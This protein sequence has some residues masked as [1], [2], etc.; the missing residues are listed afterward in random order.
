MK[1][2]KGLKVGI[3]L[4]VAMVLIIENNS[5]FS[6]SLFK[7]ENI[8]SQEENEAVEVID[9]E[10]PTTGEDKSSI[11]VN[12][13]EEEFKVIDEDV[14]I[15]EDVELMSLSG[16]YIFD[17]QADT[18]NRPASLSVSI[19]LDGSWITSKKL[20]V[21]DNGSWQIDELE[22]TDGYI[23]EYSFDGGEYYDVSKAGNTIT[24][25]L[26]QTSEKQIVT[27]EIPLPS[28]S[29]IEQPEEV[30]IVEPQETNSDVS[31]QKEVVTVVSTMDYVGGIGQ[32]ADTIVQTLKG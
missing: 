29:N 23:V 19:Y 4:M 8:E 10:N 5:L 20:S 6:S 7:A 18:S 16:A 21:V 26:K 13:I 32:K 31:A 11:D 1:M 24:Y 27:E 17:D 28:Q 25:S 2:R 12:E 22:N 14:N 30:K 9:T 3:A 15:D